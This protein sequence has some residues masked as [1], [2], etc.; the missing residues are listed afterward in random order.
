MDQTSNQV[1]SATV[2]G[3]KVLAKQPSLLSLSSETC[4]DYA[5]EEILRP[6]SRIVPPDEPGLHHVKFTVTFSIAFPTGTVQMFRILSISM[7]L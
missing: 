4:E 7:P 1:L 2:H 3:E 6:S 5:P